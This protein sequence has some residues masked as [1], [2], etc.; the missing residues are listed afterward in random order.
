MAPLS[1]NQGIAPQY[2]VHTS[3][4]PVSGPV[5]HGDSEPLAIRLNMVCFRSPTCVEKADYG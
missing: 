1:Q 4:L 5:T 2:I 3:C